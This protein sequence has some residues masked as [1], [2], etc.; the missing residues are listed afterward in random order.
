MLSPSC[1]LCGNTHLAP[2]RSAGDFRIVR[3]VE[4]GLRFLEPQPSPE[5]LARLYTETYFNSE[6]S[7]SK[8][9]E[10][11]VLE[12]SNWRATFKDRLKHLRRPHEGARLL[13]VGAAAGFF[14]EQAREAGWAAEGLEPSTWAARYAR[15]ELR[16]PVAEGLLG[17]A[18]MPDSAFDAVTFWEVIEHVP[19]PKAFLTEVARVLKP[20]GIVAFSTPDAGSVVARILGRR[21]LGWQKVPEHLFY[22]DLPTLRRLLLQC[23]FEVTETRYVSLTVSWSFALERLIASLGFRRTDFLPSWLGRRPLRVNCYYDLMV[24]AKLSRR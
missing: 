2:L 16:M 12:A 11:Y 6:A 13:D 22:F 5:Q 23:G 24:L 9:Y 3:C 15:E 21:W 8:G 20:G 17:S 1:H 19:D 7:V 4:C 10:S 18:A 14:V